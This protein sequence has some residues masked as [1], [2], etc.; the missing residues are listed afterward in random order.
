MKPICTASMPTLN[1]TKDQSRLHEK[2]LVIPSAV[3][4]P[5]PWINP[6][7]KTMTRRDQPER[8]RLKWLSLT[9]ARSLA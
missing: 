7:A 3:A 1:T 4:K 5:S 8:S 2:E 9:A 6:K